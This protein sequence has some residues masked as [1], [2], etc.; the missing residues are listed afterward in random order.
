[1]GK[2][3]ALS[4]T[5]FK[6]TTKESGALAAFPFFSRAM[7]CETILRLTQENRNKD[8]ECITI[9]GGAKFWIPLVNF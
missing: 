4:L 3:G 9:P 1:M 5:S 6:F 2:R 7:T 8:T